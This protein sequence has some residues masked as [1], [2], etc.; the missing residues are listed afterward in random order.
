MVRWAEAGARGR[1]WQ[2]G[3]ACLAVISMFGSTAGAA[4]SFPRPSLEEN[5][6]GAITIASRDA[7]RRAAE[8]TLQMYF[9]YLYLSILFGKPTAT[10]NYER[11]CVDEPASWS[12]ITQI[13]EGAARDFWQP[14]CLPVEVELSAVDPN[15]R[16]M[17][18]NAR[19]RFLDFPGSAEFITRVRQ[20]LADPGSIEFPLIDEQRGHE[21]SR[22]YRFSFN[23]FTQY[24]RREYMKDSLPAELRRLGGDITLNKAGDIYELLIRHK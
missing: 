20:S 22:H 24:A 17:L 16:S 6:P 7:W 4:L 3:A 11:Y 21:L 14:R 13:T 9:N 5:R 8:A 10:L 12:E 23:F 19:V 15:A 2:F 1:R 18:W